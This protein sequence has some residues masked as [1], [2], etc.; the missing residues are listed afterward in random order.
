MSLYKVKNLSWAYGTNRVL[1]QISFD[2]SQGGFTGI[3]GPNGSGKTTLMKLLLGFLIPPEGEISLQNRPISRYSPKE[4]ARII[5]YVPQR[6]ESY[7][8]YTVEELITMG[9]YSH[10][11]GFGLLT[12]EDRKVVEQIIVQLELSAMR[13]EPLDHLSG[14]E[15]QRVLLGRALAQQAQCILLDEPT[16]H[17]DVRHQLDLLAHLRSI[18]GEG[19]SIISIFHDINMALAYSDQIILLDRGS[20]LYSGP[21]QGLLDSGL[22][23]KVFRVH[24]RR[25]TTKEGVFIVPERGL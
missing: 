21:S 11:R 10:L 18:K 7:F 4:R 15:L 22:L 24:F 20:L 6:P 1:N 23:E 17:L 5:S 13:K 2:L 8:S 16:N 12:P 9:R 3:I 25:F 19:V 14:G